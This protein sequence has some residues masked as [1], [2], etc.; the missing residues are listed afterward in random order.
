MAILVLKLTPREDHLMIENQVYTAELQDTASI[1][2]ELARVLSSQTFRRASRMRELLDFAVKGTF[3]GAKLTER[4]AARVV[5]GRGEDF[6]SAIDPEV[7][8]QYG[9]LRRKLAEYYATEGKGSHIQISLPARKYVPVF[10]SHHSENGKTEPTVVLGVPEPDLHSIAVL[11]FANLTADP[12]NDTFCYGLTEELITS[13]A[14]K[15]QV[16]VVA[17]CSAF[18]FKD[19]SVDVRSA[20]KLLGVEM[21]LEGSVR[22]EDT[23]T[24]VTVR[25]ARVNDG[26]AIWSNSFNTTLEGTL[27]TQQAMASEI[28]ESMPNDSHD[29][30]QR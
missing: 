29:E 10:L 19:K 9:R 5:F 13:L 2:N 4:D 18:Q 20:G 28:I 21:I 23:Q 3:N 24:R 30:Q 11:P 26:I 14:S 16:N 7:R 22:M 1:E 25:L 27:S 17:S 6:D 15:P 8:I 12:N